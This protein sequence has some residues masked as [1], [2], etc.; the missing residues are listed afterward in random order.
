LASQSGSLGAHDCGSRR[1]KL[2][3]LA[4]RSLSLIALLVKRIKG[5]P[6]V[7]PYPVLLTPY[8]TFF[9]GGG[10]PVVNWGSIARP[11]Y[12]L[13]LNNLSLFEG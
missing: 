7:R 6:F 1:R 2:C 3:L 5:S 12:Y 13:P 4:H 8:F 10:S 9:L 11:L